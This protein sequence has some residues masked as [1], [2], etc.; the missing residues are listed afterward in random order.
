MTPPSC[1]GGDDGSITIEVEGG[2]NTSYD[3]IWVNEGIPGPT[4]TNITEGSYIY[5]V[6]DGSNCV[7]TDTII[8][9]TPDTLMVEINPLI[10]TS[11]ISCFN[12]SMSRIGLLTNGGN[13][14]QLI[15]TWNP[16]VSNTDFA[17]NLGPGVYAVTVTDS[18]GCTAET[19]YE[20]ISAEPIEAIINASE[21]PDCFGGQTCVSVDTAFGGVGNEYTFTIN[22][23]PRFPLD[24]C[25]NVFAG[26]YLLT[27]FDSAG[28]SIDTMITINQPEEIIVDLGPDVTIN[29]GEN[30][31]PI[32]AFIVSELDIDSIFLGSH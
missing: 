19:S 27:V 31:D 25:I 20:L 32:S 10:T 18:K 1:A 26:S 28:C 30:T 2:N 21:E 12:D 23:G 11:Q 29:L 15:Y 5:N 8:L 13:S 14:G 16:A 6:T 24:T 7:F 4:L 3:I 22:V 9:V 17:D